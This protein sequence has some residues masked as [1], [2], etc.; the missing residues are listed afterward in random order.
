MVST[1]HQTQQVAPSQLTE[2]DQ[3]PE[4]SGS[5]A[6]SFDISSSSTTPEQGT[7]VPEAEI[8]ALQGYLVQFLI[9]VVWEGT[10]GIDWAENRDMSLQYVSYRPFETRR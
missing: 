1:G 10:L 8:Q 3:R 5:H 9:S 2:S 7:T 4:S 6:G